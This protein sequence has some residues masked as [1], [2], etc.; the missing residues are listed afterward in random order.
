MNENL[1]RYFECTLTKDAALEEMKAGKRVAH[2]YF[3]SDEYLYLDGRIIR[4]EEGYNF[5]C[6]WMD[7]NSEEWQVGWFV[8]NQV[9][10]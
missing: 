5:N 8:V 3:A 4:T 2:R 1:A 10:N 7:R 6:G 9:I